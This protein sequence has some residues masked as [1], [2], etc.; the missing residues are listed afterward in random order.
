MG[1]QY[2]KTENRRQLPRTPE[3]EGQGWQPRGQKGRKEA[4]EE[5]GFVIPARRAREDAVP[6]G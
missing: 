6:A 5:E 3:G 4:R 2:N 1:K